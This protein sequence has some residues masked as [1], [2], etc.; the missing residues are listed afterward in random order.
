MAPPR[1]LSQTLG[2]R[3]VN[4]ANDTDLHLDSPACKAE[5]IQRIL[6]FSGLLLLF[7][8]YGWRNAG[9]YK[10]SFIANTD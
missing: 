7:C 2:K 4:Y 10:A 1:G 6:V 3:G 5:P 8:K 9:D